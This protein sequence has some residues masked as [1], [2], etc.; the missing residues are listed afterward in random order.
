LPFTDIPILLI[1]A[2]LLAIIALP[3][4]LAFSIDHAAR[5]I[6][7]PMWATYQHEKASHV[8]AVTLPPGTAS[9]VEVK[10]APRRRMGLSVFGR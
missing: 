5:K 10:R 8:V 7:R 2:A 9:P 1:N 6:V 4:V 3:F